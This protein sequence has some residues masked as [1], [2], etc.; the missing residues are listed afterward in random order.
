MLFPIRAES[1]RIKGDQ[2]C[3]AWLR[4]GNIFN[5]RVDFFNGPF[6]AGDE[7]DAP[8]PIA[9]LI[10]MRIPRCPHGRVFMNKTTFRAKE[11]IGAPAQVI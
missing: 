5:G 10:I 7:A 8:R 11:Q 4:T 3:A 2:R 1:R 6:F 9:F